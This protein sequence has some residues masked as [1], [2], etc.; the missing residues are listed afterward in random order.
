MK[1]RIS[2]FAA[3]GKC[4]EG[5]GADDRSA[6]VIDLAIEANEWF[7]R[8]DI[9]AAV[10][11]IRT[12][13]LNGDKLSAW[14]EPYALPIG[15]P[16]RIGIIMAG[17]IPLVGFFDLLCVVVTGNHAVVKYSS[18]DRVLMSYIVE[19]IREIDPEVLI[20][21]YDEHSPL[22]AVIATGSDNTNRYFRAQFGNLPSLLRGSRRSVAILSER[23]SNQQ[24]ALLGEDIFRYSGLGCRNVSHLF[25]P[26]GYDPHT[27]LSALG[28]YEG[29]NE[30]Y[31]RNYLQN[32]ALLTINGEQ[33]IDGGFFV[34]REGAHHS[35]YISELTYSF[36]NTHSELKEHLTH[37]DDKLQ[38]VV[39]STFQHSRAVA[40]GEAQR[41]G[42]SGYPDAIDV[43]EFLKKV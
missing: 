30:K 32:R 2:L 16:K 15:R 6:G 4:L 11:A 25:L 31:R 8:S 21:Q 20:S 39:S 40:F 34:M 29:I 10:E 27:L 18:K 41:P 36:Y 14:L 23:Q 38:C 35:L 26:T 22:D 19:T 12:Q 7:T 24:L 3:L 5:F 1:S 42:L 9:V 43:I 37:S 13:M 33:F 17:N 28:S